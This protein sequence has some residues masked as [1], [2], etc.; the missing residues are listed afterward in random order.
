MP[1]DDCLA[2]LASRKPVE[3][4]GDYIQDEL[5]YCGKCHTPKQ[6]RIILL[7]RPTVV[8]VMCQCQSDEYDRQERMLK[9][10]QE[11]IRIS[12]LRT[13]GLMDSSYRGFTF[14]QDDGSNPAMAKARR[15]V[16][17]WDEM[18]RENIG[19]VL[20]G[21][22]GTGKTFFAGSIANALTEH[23][24]PVLMTNFV[25]LVNA[26]DRDKN[27]FLDELGRYK[28]LVLDDLGAERQSSYMLEQIYN[29]VDARYRGGLPAI[30][31]TNLTLGEMK[32]PAEVGYQRIYDRILGCC[33]PIKFDG[34]S[35]R[36]E[37]RAGKL[38][39]ARRL[40]DG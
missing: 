26:L 40:L 13:A 34:G 6:S 35:K 9:E 1:I 8:T 20:F 24:V 37:G 39:M 4:P 22:V 25:R 38:D 7:G 10:K 36:A 21:N 23:K 30:Y 31:T 15:Y 3:K 12:Q 19:L 2:C 14:E 16:E 33:V 27:G 32:H 18:L 17:Q 5:L 11:K 29:V 28:L